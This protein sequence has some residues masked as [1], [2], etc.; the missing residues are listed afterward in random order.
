MA[1]QHVEL[2][3]FIC[4]AVCSQRLANELLTTPAVAL[5]RYGHQLSAIERDMVLSVHGAKDIFDF[6]A[7]LHTKVQSVRLPFKSRVTAQHQ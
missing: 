7:R 5:D 6:A 1:M 2:E 4:A 3:R